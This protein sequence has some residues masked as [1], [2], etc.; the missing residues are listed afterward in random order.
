MAAAGA[1]PRFSSPRF[2]RHWGLS[3]TT[4]YQL[5]WCDASI[6][7]LL[8]TPVPPERRDR[9]VRAAMAKGTAATLSLADSTLSEEEVAKILGGGRLPG[10]RRRLAAEARNVLKAARMLLKEASRGTAVPVSPALVLR[11]HRVV[12]KDLG[13]H[14]GATPG[15]FRAE[16]GTG[17]IVGPPAR[18][19]PALVERLCEWLDSEFPD[20]D[21]AGPADSAHDAAPAVVQ[22]VATH[23]YLAW[24]RPFGDG[25]GRTARLLESYVLM[26]AGVP[27]AACQLL[28]VH[29]AK[30]RR[31]YE[32]ILRQAIADRSLTSFVAYAVGGFRDGLAD[33]ER[34]IR[35]RQWPAAWRALV[36]ARFD[37]HEHRKKSVFRRRRELALSLPLDRPFEPA[38]LASLDPALARTY[39]SL[40]KRTLQ[41]DLEVLAEMELAV[42]QDG[43]FRAAVEALRLV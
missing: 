13:A 10:S 3:P 30:R 26:R 12:G 7:G 19:V 21:T 8:E 16:D 27:A 5:G 34:A 35:R 17:D 18:D 1:T 22:A 43:E 2:R 38:D 14:F 20:A 40:S 25:N 37:A 42:E 6:A 24:I 36:F 28:S 29:Y 41:R 4:R 32:R 31:T 39:D 9:L 33:L 15:Q 23:V 11:T